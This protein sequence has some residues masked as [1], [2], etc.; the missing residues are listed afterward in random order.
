MAPPTPA[1]W[2]KTLQLVEQDSTFSDAS[3]L[4]SAGDQVNNNSSESE[5]D[6]YLNHNA[7]LGLPMVTTIGNHDTANVAYD[8]HFNAANE[9]ELGKTNA[10]GD[11]YFVYNNVLF[12]VLNTN[13][14]ST[15][16]HKQF[17]E[18]AIRLPRTRT[19]LEG[20]WSITTPSIPP[21]PTPTTTM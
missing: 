3:F 10:G 8:R 9:S 21:H 14:T 17:M 11:S 18:Q 6:G 5:Y 1:N 15:A 2:G 13:N 7:F 16:E 12:M 4:L 20:S 19:S